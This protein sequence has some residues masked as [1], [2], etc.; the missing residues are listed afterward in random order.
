VLGTAWI[1]FLRGR[2]ELFEGTWAHDKMRNEKLIGVHLDFSKGG[3]SAGECTSCL[4][5]SINV[6]LTLA[7]RV[8]GYLEGA[9]G[10]RVEISADLL[11][12]PSQWALATC[13]AIVQ[14][15][16]AQLETISTTAGRRVALFIDEYDW[17][18]VQALG[19]KK[20]FD[21]L[22]EFFA[23]LFTKLKACSVV[24][25]LFVTGSSRLA[26]KGFFSGANNIIDL[27]YDEKAA[28][29]LGYTWAEFVTL[30][31]EQLPLLEKLHNMNRDE[32]KAEMERW[33]NFYRWSKDVDDMV[34][35]PL[36]VNMFVKTGEFAARWKNTADSTLLFNKSLFDS[37]VMRL[38]LVKDARIMV[39]LADLDGSSPEARLQPGLLP[40]GQM[41]VLVS[42]G[43][44]SI[45]PE[46]S[47]RDEQLPLFIPNVEARVQVEEI[48][49]ASFQ[50]F[51]S[52]EVDQAVRDYCKHSDAVR[53]LVDLDACGAVA[54][55]AL[56]LAGG[57][58]VIEKHVHQAI[59]ALVLAARKRGM[60]S[61]ASELGVDKVAERRKWL[62]LAFAVRGVGYAIE[63]VCCEEPKQ[64][65]NAESDSL[66]DTLH[67]G[68]QQLREDY[69]NFS[70]ENV[71]VSSRFYSCF[72]FGK[73][74]KLIAYTTGLRFAEIS[75]VQSTLKRKEDDDRVV[76]MKA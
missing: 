76:W 74:A 32:L 46:C 10:M 53:L 8:E 70:L 58:R 17:P 41:A 59:A 14:R 9:K 6:G 75:E 72:L 15:L 40:E 52:D 4:L 57:D 29:A 31:W 16:L 65:E 5:D 56:D 68:L 18:C 54:T 23:T 37:D 36:S 60:F 2:K 12:D 34:F 19:D 55:C 51:V 48:L 50:P 45:A 20:Q 61:I 38:L 30:Y 35:N 7:E 73:D 43:I 13:T 21:Q 28:A 26:M 25:F 39:E 11:K 47:D 1:E 44:L 63:L 3:K 22:N 66:R 24:P 69:Q 71:E 62:D 49:K 27:T 33:Y 67:H 64:K 42:S